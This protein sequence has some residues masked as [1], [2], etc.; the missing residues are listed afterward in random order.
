[1][2]TIEELLRN[3][4]RPE[5]LEFGLVTNRLPSVNIG[6]KFE[7]VDDE[8]PSTERL[9]QMLVTMGGSR[10]VDSLSDKP[11]QW[12]TRLDGVGVIAVAAIMRKDIVQARFTVAKREGA[13]AQK[14]SAGQP[15]AA[16][17]ISEKSPAATQQ[18]RTS[19]PMQRA[20]PAPAPSPQ[21]TSTKAQPASGAQPQVQPPSSPTRAQPAG[22]SSSA[23]MAAAKQAVPLQG[24]AVKGLSGGASSTPATP[25]A[26]PVG[27]PSTSAPAAAPVPPPEDEWDD[28]DEPTLQTLSPPVTGHP[29]VSEP[30]PKPARRPEDVGRRE[31]EEGGAQENAAQ[32]RAAAEQRAAEQRAAEQRAAEQR[33]AEQR[34]AEQRAAEQRAAEQR[35]A[36]Q[37]AAE[38]RAAEQRAAEQRAAEQRAAEQ[39]AAEQRAAEQRAAEQ[40]AAEQRA[41]EQR[42]AAEKAAAEKAAAERAAAEKAAAERAAQERATAELARI[43]EQ[44]AAQERQARERAAAEPARAKQQPVTGPRRI[45]TPTSVDAVDVEITTRDAGSKRQP[46]PIDIDLDADNGEPTISG[47]AP[48]PKAQA[49]GAQAPAQAP[50]A[51]A[52]AAQPLGGAVAQAPGSAPAIVP[53]KDRP[54]VDPSA[55]IDSFLAMAVAARA[56]DLHI[57][58]G[59]PILLRVATDL[60]PRTQSLTAEH[61][62]RITKEIVPARLRDVLERDGACEFAVE[63]PTHGR[64]RVNAS[65]QSTGYKLSMRV[66]PREPAT[67][68]ALGL[69]E[70]IARALHHQRGLVLVTGPVAHGKST[71]LAALVDHINRE[72][73]RHIMTIEEPIE[74]VHARKKSLVSQREIGLH[75]RSKVQA[76]QATLRE[77]TDVLVISEM[78]D[79][80][81]IRLALAA[82][83]SGR[84][85]LGAMA[86]PSAAKAIDRILELFTPAEVPTVRANLASA[87]R[88][89]IGQRLVPSADRTR[90]C[91]AVE[92]L[93]WSVALYGLIRDGR[94]HQI[95]NLQQ[96]GKPL[97][98]LRLDESL[99]ELVRTNK[100]TLDVAKQFAESPADLETQAARP[101]AVQPRK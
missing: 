42:A 41:A 14:P 82:V 20:V 12:T 5:V 53:E 26:R 2:K 50:G 91:A 48:D 54:K 65:R 9:M 35:A 99:A 71:T 47:L 46:I 55:S 44:R 95:P 33:A 10:Y 1:M 78:R 74:H 11:V 94:T 59:R 85:V 101:A 80:E 56:S 86:V 43:R 76:I 16:A 40:R 77:D 97:G 27:P 60:L 31:A 45:S 81:T 88:L 39:R 8:A 61:V 58:A 36:E 25:A 73:A 75:T 23:S 67:L 49:P 100:V 32:E 93:P 68:A 66:I 63:H 92:L 69:P 38:Q 18:A 4:A 70:A 17:R 51:Q 13:S 52:A 3:L 84:L 83:E 30:R 7:P 98:V 24:Q 89:V 28:D 6:G 15:Q 64:F 22:T 34:A 57:I 79:A 96:R 29:G 21:P 90:L 87:L 37:R 72:S 19:Q 62:E